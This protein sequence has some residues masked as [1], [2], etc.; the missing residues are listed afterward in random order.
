MPDKQSGA[1]L[2]DCENKPHKI[3]YQ[4]LK[5]DKRS[6]VCVSTQIRITD[7]SMMIS[8]VNDSMKFP[9]IIPNKSLVTILNNEN[10]SWYL[11]Q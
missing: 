6:S 4:R 9:A 11:A 7:N 8:N 2:G 10:C 3:E 5:K 1:R